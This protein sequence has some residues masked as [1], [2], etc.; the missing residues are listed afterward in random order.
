MFKQLLPL[1]AKRPLTITVVAVEGDKLRLNV[2]PHSLEKDGEINDKITHAHKN[3]VAAIPDGAIKALTTPLSVLATPEELDTDL[4][5]ILTGFVEQHVSLQQAV[6]RATEEIAAAIKVVDDRKKQESK[7]KTTR[8]E[9]KS[10][11]ADKGVTTEETSAENGKTDQTTLPMEW[12]KPAA[13]PP[14]A[15]TPEEA[16]GAN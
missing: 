6:N 14:A 16:K 10:Q 11:P 9:E 13:A 12:C 2:V 15:G 7:V 1:V 3:E 5:G 4:A 8:K